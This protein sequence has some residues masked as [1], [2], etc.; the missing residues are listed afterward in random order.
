MVSW[1]DQKGYNNMKTFQKRADGDKA[2]L[3]L[4]KIPK[5][6]IS[7]ETGDVLLASGSQKE[8]DQNL[9]MFF[10]QRYQGKYFGQP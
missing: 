6:L 8:I 4:G 3:A 5:I 7:G 1:N 9:G 10:T 2:Y